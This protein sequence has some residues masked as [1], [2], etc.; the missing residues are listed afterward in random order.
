MNLINT[1]LILILL[2]LFLNYLTNNKLLLIF[3]KYLNYYKSNIETFIGNSKNLPYFN[4]PNIPYQNQKDFPY[5][6][7]DD[8]KQLYFFINSFIKPNTNIYELTSSNTKR[9][10]ADN[11]LINDL[12]NFLIITF[13]CNGFTFYNIKL[14]DKIYYYNNPRGAE[15]EP[16]NFSSDVYYNGKKIDNFNFYIELFL[17]KDYNY[18]KNIFIISLIKLIKNSNRNN[19]INSNKIKANK[20]HLKNNTEMINTFNDIFIKNNN[21]NNEN[22]SDDSLIPSNIELS[23]ST[24]NLST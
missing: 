17:R 9:N 19:K 22:D 21:N 14:L 5:F 4:T 10:N 12:I 13:N 16:F 8:I 1:I 20:E 23:N 11:N 2:L 7:N 15:I 18:N 24:D 3:K 6:I